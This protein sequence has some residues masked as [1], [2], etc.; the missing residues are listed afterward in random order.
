MTE[1]ARV[2]FKCRLVLVKLCKIYVILI[3]Y[4]V[5]YPMNFEAIV[6]VFIDSSS[7]EEEEEDI[8]QSSTDYNDDDVIDEIKL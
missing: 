7:K 3:E 2:G 5:P 1:P 4:C 8:E 6:D